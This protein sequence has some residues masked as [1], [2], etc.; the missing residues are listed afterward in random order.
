[1]SR[2]E[3][4]YKHFDVIQ[5]PLVTEKSTVASAHGQVFFQVH[6]DATKPM[7]KAAV[8]HVFNVKVKAVNT[9]SSKGKTRRFRGRIGQRSDTK[10]A[11]VT[12]VEGHTIDWG[13]GA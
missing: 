7:I 4:P 8:E 11:M 9:I 2:Q 3:L 5:K 13:T 12:L 1:M 6:P 10:K